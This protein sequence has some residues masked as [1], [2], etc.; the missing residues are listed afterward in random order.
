MPVRALRAAAVTIASKPYIAL[1]RVTARSF[2]EHNPDIPFFLLLTDE[3]EGLIRREREPF[4]VIH[5]DELRIGESPSFRFQYTELELSYAS[6]PFVI[7]H[8]LASGFEAVVFLKQETLV[9]A[10][11]S[12]VLEELRGHSALLTPHLL[13]PPAGAGAL[14]GE[15]NVLRA[16][17][18][19]GGFVAFAD[20]EESR[21]FLA[22][23]G[24]RTARGC[25][26]AVEAGVH[27][28]QRWLDFA[29]AFM[30]SCHVLRDPGVNVGHWNLPERRIRA[31]DGSVTACGVPCRV[32]RFSG[33][34]PGR[35]HMVTKYNLHFTVE[36][37]G[38][39]AAVFRMY[40]SMLRQEGY[41]E[42]RA[43]PYAYGRFSDGALVPEMGR[44]IY[45]DLAGD[46]RQFGNPFDVKPEGSYRNWLRQPFGDGAPEMISN[47]WH[48]VYTRRKDLQRR[49]PDLAGRGG[50]GYARWIRD[51]GAAEY[52]VVQG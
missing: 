43:W 37:T 15:I 5:L 10:S 21:R 11:L 3:E 31:R 41:D 46:A 16:G 24:E 29:P 48:G 7:E 33:Y 42:T 6:T 12:P 40:D 35:P 32:F 27:F 51:V 52:G 38:E 28:E 19:N 4:E 13:E 36:S 23:W 26:R 20:C 8:L 30:P 9:L 25:F 2:R 45:H 44:R 18:Y 17:V 22:W 1:A 34:E 14:Q 50:A 47:Y 49:F 39:A